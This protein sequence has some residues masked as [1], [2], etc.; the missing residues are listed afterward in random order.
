MKLSKNALEVLKRR[1]LRR[2]E[3]G[4]VIETPKEMFRRVAHHVA[5][6]DTIYGEKDISETEEKFYN[7]M[8]NFEFLPNSPT[9]MNAGT[10]IGQLSAC[11]VLPVG[12]SIEEIF[13]ALKYM[14]LIHK[15][16]GG[17]GFSFSKL[18]PKGDV[19]ASTGGVASG[20]VSFMRIFDVATDVIKQGGRRRGANMGVLRY[21]HP[22]IEEFIESKK[23]EGKFSNFN[24]SVA[25]DEKFMDAVIKN[26]EYELINPR[27]KKVVK[28]VKARNIFRKI[29][30]MAWSHGDP[31]MIFLDHINKHN[32]TPHLGKIEAT[33]PCV[34]ADTWVMTSKG[35]R[36]VKNLINT[37]FIAVVN[38]KEYIS[39]TGFFPT[40]VKPVYKIITKEGFEL[41]ATEDHMVLK[42]NKNGFEWVRVHEL[43]PGDKLVMNN[44][45]GYNWKGISKNI[46]CLDEEAEI[47][48]KKSYLEFINK[49]DYDDLNYEKL[50][51]LQRMLLRLG[52]FSKIKKEK[53]I[54][55]DDNTEF[56]STVKKIEFDGIE[57]VYD[58]QI[59][60]INAFDANGF[61]V[62][63]CGEQPL[64]PYESCNLGSINLTK[65]V[66]NK[67]IDWKK[68]R[69]ITRIAIHFLDNVIDV[70]KYPTKEI[71]KMTKKTRKVGLG[72]M[73]FADMLIKLGI[74]YDSP[75]ALQ[76]A[77]KLMNFISKEARKKSVELGEER[78]SFPSF[79]GS[80]WEKEGY[81]HMRNATTTT[82]A[83]TGTLSIIANV[84]SSIEPIF[85]IAFIREV[86]EGTVLLEIHPLFEKIAKERGFYS[87]DLMKKIAKKGSIQDFDEIPE[88]IRRLFVT[89]HDIDPIWH[90]KMQAAFQKYVDNAVSKTVNLPKDAKPKDV[91]RVFLTAYKLGCKGITV[92][93]YGSKREQVLKLN[94]DRYIVAKSEYA[95]ACTDTTCPS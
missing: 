33:N 36:K 85:A 48:S 39:E 35:P 5:K 72:V 9:L 18:R 16:G 12:D 3:K 84:S 91:E 2:N 92:Y 21:D 34:T 70:N 90:V 87:L 51:I 42:K 28:K 54:I 6:A 69:R 94:A 82:I 8:K 45:R 58:T 64:L 41:R 67:K 24:I 13:D 95:G 46:S 14:A 63:N 27:N 79:K 68:L 86:M 11:F 59:P 56:T 83:P 26:K 29:V 89:S 74:P 7:I 73:G 10:A 20:P 57:T 25:A 80:K 81:E 77:E 71:E 49:L 93:R 88:D 62:H 4:E 17:V 19:V 50:K 40:G 22:D 78:G 44:H 65:I 38:G 15:S 43:K 66:K 61:Y 1:Y 32:P 55:E 23:V 52:V 75:K 60:G 37:K 53:L 30:K 76:I 47:A 31:G